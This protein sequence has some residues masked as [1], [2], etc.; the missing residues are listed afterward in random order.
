MGKVSADDRLL[1]VCRSASARL[2]IYD[3]HARR[4]LTAAKLSGARLHCHRL[5]FVFSRD[6]RSLL[7][8]SGTNVRV[9]DIGSG[10]LLHSVEHSGIAEAALSP[11][12]RFLAATDDNA[13]LMWRLGGPS[14]PVFRYPLISE[15]AAS[16]RWAP[17]GR[18]I[19]F[20]SG[21][22]GSTVRSV[23]LGRAVDS[24]W[25]D[26]PVSHA[27]FSAE[28]GVLATAQPSGSAVRV[29]LHRLRKG[30]SPAGANVLP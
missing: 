25:V 1:A 14:R 18:V 17:G 29:R 24:A 10:R 4:D 23:D 21:V 8:I 6:N 13:I 22:T 2:E 3:L 16:L 9:W 20:L 19:R 15:T 12:G 30:E 27:Y 5:R 26:R 11:D 28:A 7:T